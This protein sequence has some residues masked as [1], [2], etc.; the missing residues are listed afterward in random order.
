MPM[1]KVGHVRMVVHE[2][3]VS[4]PVTVRFAGWILWAV[5]VLVVLVMAVSMLMRQL[6]VLVA[7]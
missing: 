5:S 7:V 6:V 2:M 3:N 4:V 1:V